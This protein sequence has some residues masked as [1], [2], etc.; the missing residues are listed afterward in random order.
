MVSYFESIIEDSIQRGDLPRD[1][2]AHH[3]Y[4][5]AVRLM[6]EAEI[7]APRSVST[8]PVDP[9]V[10]PSHLPHTGNPLIEGSTPI[11]NSPPRN[12]RWRPYPATYPVHSD[13][14]G[15]NQG[16]DL[17]HNILDQGLDCPFNSFGNAFN[18]EEAQPNSTF[19]AEALSALPPPPPVGRMTYT[20]HSNFEE[21]QLSAS[22]H[23]SPDRIDHLPMPMAAADASTEFNFGGT[24]DP[25]DGFFN[26]DFDMITTSMEHLSSNQNQVPS[27]SSSAKQLEADEYS[28]ESDVYMVSD[29]LDTVLERENEL[30]SALA[31]WSSKLDGN[32]FLRR[33]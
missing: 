21:Y 29:P 27:V 9:L 20:D 3:F 28:F 1:D 6:L 12:L 31:D 16:Y 18:L 2:R 30:P 5:N 8:E 24:Q 32:K 7:T 11:L 23:S 15:H 4:Q 19:I 25:I 26:S 33:R 10:G 13:F 22:V 14:G 17:R